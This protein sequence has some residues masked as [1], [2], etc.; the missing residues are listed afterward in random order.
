[1]K[2]VGKTVWGRTQRLPF[3]AGAE[4]FSFDRLCVP[5]TLLSNGYRG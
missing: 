4:Y 3:Q 1:M 2:L 5:L